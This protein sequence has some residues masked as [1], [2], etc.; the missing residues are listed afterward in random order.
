MKNLIPDKFVQK[1]NWLQL[2]SVVGILMWS[3][4]ASAA[5]TDCSATE[6]PQL[7]CE[8]LV[9]LYNSTNGPNWVDNQTN[10]WNKTNTPCSWT[11]VTCDGSSPQQHVISIIR[12]EQRLVGELPP[13]LNALTFLQTLDLRNGVGIV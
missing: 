6:I 7:E 5:T 4:L 2:L 8:A 3:S 12:E 13:E 10:N 1:I 11:G 9:A